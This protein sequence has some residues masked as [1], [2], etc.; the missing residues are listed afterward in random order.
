[1]DQPRFLAA[2]N[3]SLSTGGESNILVRLRHRDLPS[4]SS[5]Q[6][7]YVLFDLKCY[8]HVDASCETRCFFAMAAPYPS[9]NVAMYVS[10]YPH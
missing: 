5:F 6:P 4:N 2:F 7:K 8:P 1:M 3:D 9:R 10:E